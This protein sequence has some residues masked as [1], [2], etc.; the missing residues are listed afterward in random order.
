MQEDRKSLGD[1]SPQIK[2]TVD[3][4]DI[5]FYRFKLLKIPLEGF[6]IL[7]ERRLSVRARH[8]RDELVR[9]IR[10]LVRKRVSDET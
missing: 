2:G 9:Q 8:G 3:D 5:A 10:Q 6:E 4:L 7:Q 1:F